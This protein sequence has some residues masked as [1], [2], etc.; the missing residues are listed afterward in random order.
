LLRR[1]ERGRVI[2]HLEMRGH[3]QRQADRDL[4]QPVGDQ[5]ELI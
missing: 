2:A 1:R 3:I 5:G 4:I